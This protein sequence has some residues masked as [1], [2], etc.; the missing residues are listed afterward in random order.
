MTDSV[1]Y[2]SKNITYSELFRT[3]LI[4]DWLET[5]DTF[6]KQVIETEVPYG[7]II[8]W[9]LPISFQMTSNNY[10]VNQG[11]ILCMEL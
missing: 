6:D 9:V 5:F 3:E 8:N 4:L 7:T 11:S 10:I 1:P 2:G